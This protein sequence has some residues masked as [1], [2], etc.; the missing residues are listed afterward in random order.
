[1]PIF[2]D[3][4]WKPGD[5]LLAARL[6]AIQDALRRL[7]K[8]RG[9]PGIAVRETN[10]GLQI[11]GVQPDTRY[12]ARASGPIPPRVGSTAGAGLVDVCWV[13]PT[14]AVDTAG[15]QLPV[16]NLD[17][18][19]SVKDQQH[20]WVEQ[21]P[22]GAW[23]LTGQSASVCRAYCT[24][25]IPTGTKASPSSSGA[26]QIVALDSSGAWVDAGAPVA[27][28]NDHTLSASIAT[29]KVLKIGKIGGVFWLLAADC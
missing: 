17:D 11:T 7:E 19:L 5:P 28:W 24:T 14:G 12:F 4:R 21:D 3:P 29:A 2:D 6:N 26:A 23:V 18:C 27:V 16:W 22:F 15:F 10:G 8:V 25:A 9:G 13:D 1:M 20:V